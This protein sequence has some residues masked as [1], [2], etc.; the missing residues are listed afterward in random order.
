MDTRIYIASGLFYWERQN[1]DDDSIFLYREFVLGKDVIGLDL[2]SMLAFDQATLV[3]ANYGT[4]FS[5]RDLYERK[6]LTATFLA[7]MYLNITEP[8]CRFNVLNSY[9]LWI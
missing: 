2:E 8:F 4:F 9:G 7:N 3:K 6:D 5:L 1:F